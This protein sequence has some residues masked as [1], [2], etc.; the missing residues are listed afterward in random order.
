[1]MQRTSVYHQ[2]FHI[3]H[4]MWK[5][6]YLSCC[7]AMLFPVMEFYSA[8]LFWYWKVPL[9]NVYGSISDLKGTWIL[10][11]RYIKCFYC[12]A[13]LYLP[14]LPLIS[15]H[16]RQFWK[17]PMLYKIA[18]WL[19]ISSWWLKHIMEVWNFLVVISIP[20][21]TSLLNSSVVS[22]CYLNKK[23]EFC[24]LIICYSL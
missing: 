15:F 11:T 16:V 18:W 22:I 24:K 21:N 13:L 8:D 23:P 4:Y 14:I 6:Y 17:L 1:M 3:S 20:P 7:S 10:W 9:Y 12:K 19:L 2:T 5:N